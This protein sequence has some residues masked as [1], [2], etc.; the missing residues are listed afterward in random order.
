MLLNGKEMYSRVCVCEWVVSAA[1]AEPSS[2]PQ[3]SV[4]CIIEADIIDIDIDMLT[5]L[6]TTS[7]P[8]GRRP[9]IATLLPGQARPGQAE[10]LKW[11]EGVKFGG[12]KGPGGKT[13]HETGSLLLLPSSPN[14]ISAGRQRVTI[15]HHHHQ[16][17]HSWIISWRQ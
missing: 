5:H 12:R 10:W 16:T 14:I 17:C 3:N 4:E 6:A 9:A 2:L 7:A 8:S 1:A 11:L 15:D 13:E